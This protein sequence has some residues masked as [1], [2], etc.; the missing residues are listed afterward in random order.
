[1]NNR[2]IFGSLDK[3]TQ[4]SNIVFL[5]DSIGWKSFFAKNL[6]KYIITNKVSSLFLIK[7]YNVLLDILTL[8]QKKVE[9]NLKNKLKQKQ[10]ND[11]YVSSQE[12]EKIINSI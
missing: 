7:L 4:R 8:S 5:L 1:M 9:I 6:K 11:V 2:E 10:D 3:S 12:A